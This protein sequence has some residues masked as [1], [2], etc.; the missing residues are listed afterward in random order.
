MLKYPSIL[1]MLLSKAFLLFAEPGDFLI[2]ANGPYQEHV[3]K[4]L[5]PNKVVIV[6]DGAANHLN[7]LIPDFILGDFDSISNFSI[8]KFTSLKVPLIYAEDQDYTDLEKAIFFAKANGAKAIFICCALGGNRTD[9]SLGNLSL[10]K[11]NYAKDCQIT[12]HTNKE[13]LCFLKDE[14]FQFEGEVGAQCAFFGWPLAHVSTSGLVWDVSN[15]K[16]EIG[17]AVSFCNKL[18]KSKVEIDVTGDL[19]LIYPMDY[20]KIE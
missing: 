12:L 6:L 7:D 2:I 17:D 1:I 16:T 13:I 11:K 19:L 10:L 9:H 5:A 20:E 14:K 8:Q 15:W 4:A 18:K 3:V